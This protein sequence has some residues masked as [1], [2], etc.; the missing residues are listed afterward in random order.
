MKDVENA[1]ESEKDQIAMSSFRQS[2][3]F[4]DEKLMSKS[5][6]FNRQNAGRGKV[7]VGVLLCVTV[8]GAIIGIP[9]IIYGI[10]EGISSPFKVPTTGGFVGPCPYC[11]TKLGMIN[12]WMALNCHVCQKRVVRK[13]NMFFGY[14]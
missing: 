1:E 8:F 4:Y 2:Q 6:A 12:E 3:A 5:D 13:E 9:L 11:G 7:I 14:D 10:Y